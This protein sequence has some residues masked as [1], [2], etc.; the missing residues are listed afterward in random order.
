MTERLHFVHLDNSDFFKANNVALADLLF[1]CPKAMNKIKKIIDG[2]PSYIVGGFPG[3]DDIRVALALN[4]A[5]LSGNPV[6]NK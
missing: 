1:Y 5:F 3:L 2:R 4:S 6:I